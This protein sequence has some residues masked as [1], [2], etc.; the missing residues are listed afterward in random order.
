M[1]SLIGLLSL[2]SIISLLSLLIVIV[3]EKEK[4]SANPVPVKVRRR[5]K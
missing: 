3:L 2:I 4:L 1:F 5:R